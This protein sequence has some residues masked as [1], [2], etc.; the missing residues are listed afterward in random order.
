[1]KLLCLYQVMFP[2]R[3]GTYE[4]ISKL[5]NVDFELWH[6]TDAPNSKLKNYTGRVGFSH[7][8]I[9]TF[10]V[11]GKT[12]NGGI[13]IVYHPFL[14]FRLIKHKPDAILT[15]GASSF[16][17]ATIAFLYSKL[18]RKKIIWW[19]LGSLAG[20]NSTGLSGLVHKWIRF[21][22]C[23][24]DAVF[25]YSTQ[26]ESYF[27]S[28][29][30]R[31]E[32]I[33]KAV[34][35]INTEPKL[36]EIKRSGQV[37]K[38]PGF[39]IVFVGAIT[40]QKQLEILIDAIKELSE[41]YSDVFLHIIG[42]GTYLDEIKKYASMNGKEERVV[43]HGRV[44]EGLNVMLKKYSVL[45]LPGLGGLAIVDGMLSSLPVISGRADG[46]ELDLI[47]DGVN[48]FVTDIITKVFLLDK[49]IY[50][51]DNPDEVL[52]MG[53]NSFERITGQ[54]SFGNYMGVFVS[55][56]KSVGYEE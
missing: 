2:Y 56:L 36:K 23:H 43:F 4:A 10:R 45:A 22:E 20:R 18:F 17:T 21:M 12:N 53:Q 30:V 29:G 13:S 31:P 32:R 40:P 24:C 35:V 11:K 52:R 44:T 50:L 16:I 38:D 3:V 14:F 39:N 25:A 49:L 26:A 46:T 9:L 5:N 34:N 42:D 33:F 37:V 19:S 1:M 48:G 41:K 27:E 6:G 8:Q 15:E 51:Y 55:C 47:A 7:K 28:I 54:F